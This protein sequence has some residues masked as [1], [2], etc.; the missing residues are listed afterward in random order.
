M[1]KIQNKNIKQCARLAI[2]LGGSGG[3][4]FA[5]WICDGKFFMEEIHRFKNE[6]I[7]ANGRYY[8]NFFEIYNQ[9]IKGYRKAQRAYDIQSF[10]IDSWCNDYILLTENGTMIESP[11]HYRDPRTEGWIERAEALI[12]RKAV[13]KKAGQQFA[14]FETCYHLL[15][16]LEQ[17]GEMVRNAAKL[18]FL[19]DYLSHLMGARKYTEYSIASVTGLYNITEK[20]WDSEILK[21]YGIPQKL[22]LDVVPPGTHVG[23]VSDEM[24][25]QFQMRSTDIYAVASHDTA[26]AV[27][28]M[29]TTD[30]RERMFISSGTWS[31][32]GVELDAP[33]L[34]QAVL[35]NKF[36]NE[37][38][39]EG[40]IR[41]T[42]NVMG[43]W[44][45]QECVRVWNTQGKNWTFP[46]LAKAAKEAREL[47]AW[48]DPDDEC[49]FEAACMPEKI[50][51]CCKKQGD[52]PQNEAEIAKVVYESL[53][54]KYRYVIEKAEQILKKRYKILHVVGG[55]CNNE[56]LN[57]L[58]ANYC[59]K[60][61]SVGPANAT[62]LGNAVIQMIAANELKD[63]SQ[64]R[65]MIAHSQDVF[66]CKPNHSD[67]IEAR[68]ADF[69]TTIEERNQK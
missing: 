44:I 69:V 25:M 4:L 35:E 20:K 13:F 38:G 28:A 16:A 50:I 7:I 48:I 27:A 41:F 34:D 5:V 30:E 55:G 24:C 15:A 67:K 37:G 12:D 31:L 14:R 60:T 39:A 9:I 8:W 33:L 58:T 47:N 40:K 19:P 66:L 46:E 11:R 62:A 49:F 10:G 54:C 53:A 21:A 36:G 22:F 42:R 17:D 1:T 32:V 64:A 45:I 6:I 61:L 3:K 63:L 52:I 68:Y 56:Y 43:L 18:I 23:R 26:C 51:E 59:N 2:D 65:R 57:E 29:P